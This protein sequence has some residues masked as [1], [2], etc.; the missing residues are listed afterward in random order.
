MR[1]LF[2]QLPVQD[3]NWENAR[4]NIPLAAGYLAAYAESRGLMS[5]GDWSLLDRAVQDKGSDSAVVEAIARDQPDL[6]CF[7]LYMWNL[8]RSLHV[9]EQVKGLSPRTRLVA[10]GPEVVKGMPLFAA[11]PFH[12]LVEGEGELP[13]CALLD[14][15]RKGRPLSRHY[16]ANGL[17]DLE[18]LPNPYLTGALPFE[19]DRPVHLETMRGCPGR[20]GYCYYGKNFP[21]VRRFARE[22]ATRL[23]E[24]AGSAGVRELY[25]MDPSFQA[26]EDLPERLISIARANTAGM[27]IHAELRLESVTEELGRLYAA[28]GLVSAEA[29]LQ[30]V[31]PAALEAV[32]RSWDRPGFERGVEIME[33]NHIVVKTG[34]ILGLPFDGYEQ[35]IETFDF[36][37]MHGLGQEAELYPLS[38]IPG[39]MVRDKA[40]DWGMS[41]MAKPPYWVTSTDW[42]SQDDMADAVAAFEDGFDVEWA[43]PPAPHFAEEEEGFRAFVD[44]RLGEN[45]DWMRLN[46]A[47]LANS[48]TLLVDADDPEGLSRLVRAARHLRRD[49]PF[50][51]YQ[52]VLRSDTRYPSEK[53]SARIRDA[54][55]SP[56]HYYELSRFFSL[57]PQASYQVRLFFATRNPSLAYR[58]ME[59]AADLETMLVLG[60]KGGFNADRLAEQLPFVAFDRESLPFDR[61]Y[62][63]MSIYTEYRHML[64]EAPEELFA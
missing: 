14:D 13:F 12:A 35:V 49:N 8:E 34:V 7:S 40:D 28:A 54:F 10:G 36:L 30:S 17:L 22:E 15:L 21:S 38:L 31:N 64:V 63:L 46:P 50:T 24:R 27:S 3:P 11:S 41:R 56:E 42:I 18:T 45:L 33:K 9:A 16:A 62:E 5:R 23:I 55:S 52:V 19:E 59:E 29:G 25:L 26:T 51:L 61:L 58:A 6:A 43:F 37:G 1:I 44:A 4:A 48:V 2:V 53:L 32:G 60:G 57:D 47:K 20:C 39:T